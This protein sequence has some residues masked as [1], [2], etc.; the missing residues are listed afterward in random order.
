MTQREFPPQHGIE[1]FAGKGALHASC[2]N[3]SANWNLDPIAVAEC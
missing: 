1:D 2:Q 3:L